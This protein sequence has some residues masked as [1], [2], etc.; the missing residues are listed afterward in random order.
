M[1]VANENTQPGGLV[2]LE[3]P[4]FQ[5][6]H[7]PLRAVRVESP[8]LTWPPSWVWY[9]EARLSWLQPVIIKLSHIPISYLTP[10]HGYWDIISTLS[11]ATKAVSAAILQ[12]I[13][14]TM[15]LNWTIPYAIQC[16]YTGLPICEDLACTVGNW[17]SNLCQINV[18]PSQISSHTSSCIHLPIFD[19]DHWNF[20]NTWNFP[21]I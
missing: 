9:L 4:S 5:R 18:P 14:L 21:K 3:Y 10:Q 11:T 16:Q 6:Q 17:I 12:N 7:W 19:K 15:L 8:T 13:S 2:M 20:T 1:I